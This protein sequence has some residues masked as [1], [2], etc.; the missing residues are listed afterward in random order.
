MV[1][2]KDPETGEVAL[3]PIT[4]RILT[5]G[6][7]LYTLVLKNTEGEEET[8]E[9]TDNH[10]FWVIGKGWVDSAKLESGMQIEAFKGKSLEVVSLTEA[11]RTEDTYNLTVADFHTYY[12]GE[13]QAFVHNECPCSKAS[14]L[15]LI[16]QGSKAWSKAVDSIRNATGHAVDGSGHNFR[17]TSQRDA[18]QLVKDAF[19]NK[20]PHQK[21]QTRGTHGYEYHRGNETGTVPFSND[22]Q[23]IKWYDWRSGKNTGADGHVFFDIWN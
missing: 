22:L 17:V 1:Y 2:S 9:V 3:K 18:K 13:Q 11:G 4:D 12:A 23:H 7:P 6:K 20:L 8:I 21:P 14:E 19:G 10:P 15:P 16:K 5:E